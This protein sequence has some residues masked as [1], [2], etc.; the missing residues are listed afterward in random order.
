MAWMRHRG[1]KNLIRKQIIVLAAVMAC[2][3]SGVGVLVASAGAASPTSAT[4]TPVR[5]K[6]TNVKQAGKGDGH[7]LSARHPG[8][9][10][11]LDQQRAQGKSEA[12][13][14]GIETIRPS[15]ST[16]APRTPS[17]GTG[18]NG[19]SAA[20]S[21]CGCLP[22]DGA[23]AAGPSNVVGAVNTA[24]KV[25]DTSGH[26][27]MPA[28]SLGSLFSSQPACL[29]NVSDPGVQ[30][31]SA[32]GGHYVL[33][34]LTYDGAYNSVICMAV[35]VN[36]NPTGSYWVY[37]FPVNGASNLLDFP[38]FAIGT[39]AIYLSGNQFQSGLFYSGAR[40]YAYNK[41]QME[42]GQPA[43]SVYK[44]VGNDAVGGIAD[45]LYPAKGVMTAGAYFVA[46]DNNSSSGNSISLWKWTDP[47][48]ANTFTLQGGV[49]VNTYTQPP[50]AT[51]PGGTTDTGDTRNLG[52]A[53]YNGTVYGVHT[54][55]CTPSG[56]TTTVPCLQWY[57]L[58]SIDSTPSLVQQ[59]IVGGAGQSY[60]YPNLSV[61]K[62]GDMLMGYA[63]ASGSAY[64]GVHYTGRLASDPLGTVQSDSVLKSG[65]AFI[66]GSR[67]GDYAGTQL[68]PDG[69]TVWHLEEYAQA[70]QGWG[71]WVG[72]MKFPGCGGTTPPPSNDFSISAN[73]TSLSLQPGTSGTST[74]STA[75]A[76]GSAQ[77]VSLT[78]SGAPAGAT[79][80]LNPTSVT[81]GGSST[82]TV[83][84]ATST[85]VGNYT[86]TV[87]GTEGTGTSAVTHSTNVALTVNPPAGSNP[88]VNGGFE[89]GT[90]FGWTSSGTTGV[91]SSGCHSGSYCARLGTTVPT[92]GNSS[93]AQTFKA[94]ARASTLAFYYSVSCP[95]TVR[96]D[97]A[98]ATLRDNTS[99]TTR[100]V[101]GKTCNN[102]SSLSPWA[103]VSSSLTAG[104]SYTLTLTSRDDNYPGDATYTLYDDVS[105][106]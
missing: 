29:S 59:G 5:V 51:Q 16:P 75:V 69:C 49:T 96:Y 44:D 104:H 74:I 88:I 105:V 7:G 92:N 21:Q 91:I 31:D 64:P 79:A 73:P 68:A 35:S 58:G 97:W 46:P 95:D 98:T 47:F 28:R 2:A 93:I 84:T 15:A 1:G 25:W 85:P 72:N 40:V 67:Y 63:F 8:G 61:D 37:G 26:V 13:S 50:K 56:G 41:A 6:L 34:A 66:D 53:Y 19:I 90:L 18:F 57:Q 55:G 42:L 36:S 9:Q 3:L 99:R 52:A 77:P 62:S 71:S 23:V 43:M 82:L 86:I 94:P 4:A 14:R 22:P 87:T 27:A 17:A 102:S 78:T 103:R 39:D 100:T 83:S 20:E 54:T 11:K 24:F 89:T 32:G 10:A 33:E 60:Y 65:E 30:Y 80:T 106:Q 12:T 81:A 70:G 76:S 101:L 45:T 38:Q 48:G